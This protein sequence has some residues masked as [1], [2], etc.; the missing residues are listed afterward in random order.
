MTRS[1]SPDG[2]AALERLLT[3]SDPDLLAVARDALDGLD[4]DDDARI[5]E[6]LTAWDDV[7]AVANLLMY[8]EVVAEQ[9]RMPA[10]LRALRDDA[11][12][13]LGLA[14]S[15]GLQRLAE[16][17]MEDDPE[18]DEELRDEVVTAL[19]EVVARSDGALAARAQLA[20]RLWAPER[21]APL[22]PLVAI[23]SYDEWRA[24]AAG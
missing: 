9:E 18:D 19:R 14:A 12:P 15:V 10:L 5:R 16:D 17:P 4:E 22:P 24:R 23:P 6:V 8:P 13:Y 11:Q 1:A 7:P 21:G 20:L 3:A 2:T